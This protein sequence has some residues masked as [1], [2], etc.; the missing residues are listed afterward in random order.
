MIC[1]CILEKDAD[2]DKACITVTA[3]HNQMLALSAARAAAPSVDSSGG[4]IV[5]DLSGSNSN[6]QLPQQDERDAIAAT[7]QAISQNG[8]KPLD[9]VLSM[10][11]W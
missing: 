9:N 10:N 4:N 8:F 2:M 7:C 11:I 5:W 3:A 1:C 6:N